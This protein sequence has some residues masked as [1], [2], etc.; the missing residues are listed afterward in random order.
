MRLGFEYCRAFTQDAI[1]NMNYS[2]TKI[3]MPVLALGAGYHPVLRDS[4]TMP[5]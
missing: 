2:K 4:I 5:I 1:E 3:T